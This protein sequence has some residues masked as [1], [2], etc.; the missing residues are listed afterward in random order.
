MARFLGSLL[1]ALAVPA[2]LP[3][4]DERED[5][6]T[7][8]PV[9]IPGDQAAPEFEDITD[10]VNSKPLTMKALKGKVVVVHFL[11]FG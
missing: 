5:P 7:W 11:A 9:K 3:G 10:W 6:S 8:T 2:A 1:L 4:G